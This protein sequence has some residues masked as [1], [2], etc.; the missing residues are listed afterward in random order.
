MK[1]DEDEKPKWMIKKSFEQHGLIGVDV[2]SHQTNTTVAY[3]AITKGN[4]SQDRNCE[5]IRHSPTIDD[6]QIP[7]GGPFVFLIREGCM[8]SGATNKF[9]R[10][11]LRQQSLTELTTKHVNGGVAKLK[12]AHTGRKTIYGMLNTTTFATLFTC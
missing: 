10:G 11:L 5:D 4:D 6:I 2:K 3:L 7:S 1:L 8:V 12:D 9:V